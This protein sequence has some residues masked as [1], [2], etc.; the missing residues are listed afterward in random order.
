[1]P[2]QPASSAPARFRILDPS[3][4]RAGPACVKQSADFGAGELGRD[5]DIRVLHADK[6]V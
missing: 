4:V 2:H 6:V 1:M 3:R 5:G